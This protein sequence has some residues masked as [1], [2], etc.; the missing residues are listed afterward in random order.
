M[1]VQKDGWMNVQKNGWMNVQKNGWMNVQK[2][3]WMR[4]WRNQIKSGGGMLPGNLFLIRTKHNIA[5]SG[6]HSQP[7]FVYS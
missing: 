3:E 6:K 2:D 1:N 4:E 7:I 5:T